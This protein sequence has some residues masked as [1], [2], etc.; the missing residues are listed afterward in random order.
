MS[1]EFVWGEPD[2]EGIALG[3][4]VTSAK[5]A[6]AYRVAIANRSSEPRAVVLF[7]T[8]DNTIRT[9]IVARTEHGE[10]VLPAVM[11]AT[12]V[13]SNIRMS[14]QLAPG[15]V[16]VRDGKPAAFG[17]FGP[18]KLHVVMGGV[19]ARPDELTSGQ[20]DVTLSA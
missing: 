8:L 11:P 18:A 14:I 20:V 2:A 15:E 9:R 16:V 12:P 5:G 7:A 6:C 4:A 10:S 19:K 3:L 1:D 13:S 17:L